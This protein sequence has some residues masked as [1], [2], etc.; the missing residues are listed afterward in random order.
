MACA[1]IR[2]VEWI[3]L[4]GKCLWS[5]IH[6][7]LPTMKASIWL[8]L[9]CL[10]NKTKKQTKKNNTTESTVENPLLDR[11]Y[12]GETQ[13]AMG[14]LQT[15]RGCP[16][17]FVSVYSWEIQSLWQRNRKVNEWINTASD[18]LYLQMKIAYQR[19]AY[20]LL[21]KMIQWF[22]LGGVKRNYSMT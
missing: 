14:D 13:R 19:S 8:F 4:K 12:R 2:N 15:H 10:L 18:S 22:S 20:K 5:H 16:K 11:R 21:S 7:H 17:H 3:R 6:H 9:K 1:F